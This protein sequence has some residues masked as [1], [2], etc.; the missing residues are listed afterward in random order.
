MPMLLQ[1]TT[2]KR[3]KKCKCFYNLQLK[4]KVEMQMLLQST[5]EKRKKK[6]KCFY[7]L[8]LE[9]EKWIVNASTIYNWKRKWDTN[10]SK[11][12]NW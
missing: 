5:T 4:T 11:I 3:K 2:E 12:Y 10:P 1:S 7:N 6:F 8:Q 9:N